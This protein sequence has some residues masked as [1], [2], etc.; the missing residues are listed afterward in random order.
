MEISI[1]A[2]LA[3]SDDKTTK[4]TEKKLV[5]LSTLSLRRATI[6]FLILFQKLEFLSTLSLRRATWF[7]DYK[8]MSVDISI[9]ALLAESDP[10]GVLSGKVK[11]I[12]IHALLAESDQ[13]AQCQHFGGVISIHALLAE[14]DLINKD[15]PEKAKHFYPRSP[16][17]E[18][19]GHWEM[20]TVYSGFLSTL[21]LRR[22]TLFAFSD[23]GRNIISIHALLA[24]SDV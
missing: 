9:H 15:L 5:F 10:F 16:C 21:S 24:E 7:A 4:L 14:S 20:D 3:E 6:V 17:G 8:E 13:C 19:L 11:E 23:C 12:S 22:A 18:R 2:L 1:H